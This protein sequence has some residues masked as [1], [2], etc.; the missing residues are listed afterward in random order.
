MVDPQAVRSEQEYFHLLET[1]ITLLVEPLK[2]AVTGSSTL[3]RTGQKVRPA[4]GVKGVTPEDV[5]KLFGELVAI[6]SLNNKL[7]ADLTHR[8]D[9]KTW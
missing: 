7:L 2:A 1:A 4:K 6:S 5:R 8:V 3:S 9:A